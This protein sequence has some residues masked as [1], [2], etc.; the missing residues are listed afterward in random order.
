MAQQTGTTYSNLSYSGSGSRT[1]GPTHVGGNAMFSGSGQVT[2]SLFVTAGALGLTGSSSIG[3][4]SVGTHFNQTGS[5][6]IYGLVLRGGSYTAS[7][8]CDTEYDQGVPD[9]LQ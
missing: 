7:G 6:A 9:S 5:G 8:S 3:G 1:F 4:D 2:G